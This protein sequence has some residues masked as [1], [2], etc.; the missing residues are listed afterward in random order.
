MSDSQKTPAKRGLLPPA[1]WE[2]FN[3]HL[4]AYKKFGI[5]GLLPDRA[6]IKWRHKK[7]T[8]MR[9]NLKNP[10]LYNEKIHW[11][12]LYDRRPEYV[13]M[14]DKYEVRKHV[15]KTVGEEYLVRCYGVWDTP[16][17]IPFD[18]LPDQFVLKCTHDC[19]SV[20][21][22]KDKGNLDV[23]ATRTRFKYALGENFYWH[24]R[25]W[26]YKNIRPRI[27]AEELISDGTGKDLKDYKFF[28][29]GGEPKFI[30]VDLDRF[31]RHMEN[32]YSPEWE[33]LPA[34]SLDP[35]GIDVP[36]PETL[37]VMLDVARKL[38]AGIPHVRVDLYTVGKRVYF[39][40][41]TFQNAAG[42]QIFLPENDRE[43][44][45]WWVLP[46]KKTR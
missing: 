39:G 11:S 2:V 38:S 29:F 30:K 14:V 18:D 16:E 28:C 34:Y 40:E 9:L 8:G 4:F 3:K 37:D 42:L 31:T 12:K 23:A 15:A 19:G 24:C 44:G 22:C 13:A 6:F 17:E 35:S 1:F 27:V 33:F 43:M 26:L 10:V 32:Y 7:E 41:M 36:R 45:G 21:L 20:M 25:E 5:A 46:D